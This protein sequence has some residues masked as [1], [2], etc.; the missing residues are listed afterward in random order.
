M[1]VLSDSIR[2]PVLHIYTLN[3]KKNNKHG[4]KLGLVLSCFL[5]PLIPV[6]SRALSDISLQDQTD[7]FHYLLSMLCNVIKVSIIIVGKLRR[8]RKNKTLYCHGNL[9]SE[10]NNQL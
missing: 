9:L 10:E 2:N 6:F 8:C 1:L 4:L 7:R 3:V 5:H